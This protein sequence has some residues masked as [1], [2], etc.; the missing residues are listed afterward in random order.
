MLEEP[1]EPAVPA[2]AHD[3]SSQ[4][5]SSPEGPEVATGLADEPAGLPEVVDGLPVL[6]DV[7]A[8]EAVPGGSVPVLAAAALAAGGFFAGAVTMA[9]VRRLAARAGLEALAA[10]RAVPT[11]APGS[12]RTYLVNV[13]LISRSD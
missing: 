3:P 6:A 12:S 4:G 10:D 2:R 1:L 8:V 7:R 11:W 13:R 5:R 9:V